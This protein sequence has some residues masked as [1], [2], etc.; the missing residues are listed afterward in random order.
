[1][2]H[3]WEPIDGLPRSWRCTREHCTARK[4]VEKKQGRA[5]SITHYWAKNDAGLDVPYDKA[6]P[7]PSP[8]NTH[9]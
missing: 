5:Y 4:Q 3:Q 7:C 6:P 1:M 2:R 9:D 8:T